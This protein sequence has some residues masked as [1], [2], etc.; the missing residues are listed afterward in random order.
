MIVV[1]DAG[2]TL[3][4]SRKQNETWCLA[5]IGRD[6]VVSAHAWFSQPGSQALFLLNPL[7]P[8]L[9]IIF[10]SVVALESRSP[11]LHSRVPAAGERGVPLVQI[12]QPSRPSQRSAVGM[13]RRRRTPDR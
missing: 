10:I 9:S 11:P 13:R 7:H 6:A 2:A 1:V 8:P 3:V 4:C 5:Y 12:A